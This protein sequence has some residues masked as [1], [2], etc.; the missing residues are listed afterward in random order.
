M[1]TKDAGRR[2]AAQ[3]AQFIEEVGGSFYPFSGNSSL[4]LAAEVLPPDGGRALAAISD[5][6]LRP[7]FAPATFAIERAAQLASLRQDADDVVTFA[8][9][10]VRR[11]FFGPHALAIDAYGDEA[12]VQALT[13][14]DLAN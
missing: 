2:S 6:V 13:P 8:R 3:V 4:G 5:A 14:A 11:K 12:G 9:K 10:L 7:A 1:L